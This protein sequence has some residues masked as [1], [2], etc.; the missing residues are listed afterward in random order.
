MA[1]IMAG[2]G[3]G[4][5]TSFPNLHTCSRIFFLSQEETAPVNEIQSNL[6]YISI[7]Y[8][9]RSVFHSLLFFI[10]IVCEH[11]HIHTHKTSTCTNTPMTHTM[12]THTH[13]H[14]LISCHLRAR[15]LSQF[16]SLHAGRSSQMI[17]KQ[18]M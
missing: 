6:N 9:S 12:H 5:T 4:R 11:T 13:T 2:K 14:I 7:V 17:L 16:L 15:P 10:C 3:K 8:Y 18:K 1:Y